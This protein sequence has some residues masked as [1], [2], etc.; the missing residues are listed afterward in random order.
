MDLV[1]FPQPSPRSSL[2]L[3]GRLRP[4]T[5][6]N[7]GDKLQYLAR[8]SPAHLKAVEVFVDLILKRLGN[9]VH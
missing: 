5:P 7:L 1:R 3:N 9:G 6:Q 4:S 8:K 2:R